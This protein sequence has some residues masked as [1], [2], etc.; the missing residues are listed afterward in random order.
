M[1]KGTAKIKIGI[2]KK[3]NSFWSVFET[4]IVTGYMVEEKAIAL[5]KE[6][7]KKLADE[8]MVFGN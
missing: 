6:F 2:R 7:H 5:F 4:E 8:D 3:G 1:K